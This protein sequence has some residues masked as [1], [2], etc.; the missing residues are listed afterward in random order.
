MTTLGRGRLLH[1][2]PGGD[3]STAPRCGAKTRSGAT[4]KAPAMRSRKTGD[5]T[6]CRMHGGASTGPRTTEGLERCRRARWKDG[7]RSAAQEAERKRTAA[8]GRG[9]W[10][11]LRHLRAAAALFSST[12]SRLRPDAL[13]L[14]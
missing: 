6:R 3:P 14:N 7:H 2:N 9:I 12:F 5:Y 13:P 8:E 1:G 10:A 4:C 11:E